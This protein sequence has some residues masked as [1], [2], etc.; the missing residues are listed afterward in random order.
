MM[1]FFVGITSATMRPTRKIDGSGTTIDMDSDGMPVSWEVL[2]LTAD[3][4]YNPSY[5]GN[6]IGW[7]KYQYQDLGNLTTEDYRNYVQMIMDAI[8]KADE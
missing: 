7:Q 1:A 5:Y 4:T 8:S 2:D 3:D 6:L